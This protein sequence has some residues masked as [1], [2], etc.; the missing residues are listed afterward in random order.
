MSR[1][2]FLVVQE[3]ELLDAMR[4]AYERFS[5]AVEPSSA[6]ALA[7]FPRREAQ[8]LSKR[9]AVVL[10]EGIV[11]SSMVLQGEPGLECSR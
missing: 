6:V 11:E 5:R 4:F 2:R 8:L 3:E 1:L 9:V 7:P 10:T